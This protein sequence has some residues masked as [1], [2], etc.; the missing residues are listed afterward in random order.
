M[1]GAGFWVE[2]AVDLA[3]VRERLSFTM[4]PSGLRLHLH[5]RAAD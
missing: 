3:W 4:S 1:V 2:P 5:P